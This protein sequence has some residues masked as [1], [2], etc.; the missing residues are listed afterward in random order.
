MKVIYY[1]NLMNKDKFYCTNSRDIKMIDGVE[2]LR[3]YKM[4]TNRDFLIKKDSLK[5]ISE[6]KKVS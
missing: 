3:V 5:K 2:Y 4:G 6:T 1:E